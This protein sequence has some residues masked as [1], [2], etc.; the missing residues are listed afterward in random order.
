MLNAKRVLTS[1][2]Q[3]VWTRRLW[4]RSSLVSSEL[5]KRSAAERWP[6][7]FPMLAV[8]LGELAKP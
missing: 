6:K 8:C 2:I 1:S 7:S 4:F 3:S 5:V